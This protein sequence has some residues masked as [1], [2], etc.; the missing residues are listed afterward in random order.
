MTIARAKIGRLTVAAVAVFGLAVG[1]GVLANAPK[2][3]AAIGSPTVSASTTLGW[4]TRT[5]L[6]QTY[7]ANS[8]IVDSHGMDTKQSFSYSGG[9]FTPI[10]RTAGTYVDGSTHVTVGMPSGEM[11]AVDLTTDNISF[12]SAQSKWTGTFLKFASPTGS[13]VGSSEFTISALPGN[14]NGYWQPYSVFI[15]GGY[16]YMSLY[17]LTTGSETWTVA[18]TPTTVPNAKIGD[19][20]MV[21][22]SLSTPTSFQYI[23]GIANKAAYQTALTAAGYGPYDLP[24]YYSVGPRC[25]PTDGTKIVC[26][27]RSSADDDDSTRKLDATKVFNAAQSSQDSQRSRFYGGYVAPGVYQQA[28]E[29]GK[30]YA[31]KNTVKI[32][33]MMVSIT[34]NGG[35]SWTHKIIADNGG[36]D[37]NLAYD[38]A[39][40]L[41]VVAYGGQTYPRKDVAVQW[42]EDLGTTWSSPL[43]VTGGDDAYT[44]GTPTIFKTAAKTFVLVY[45]SLPRY[46]EMASRAGNPSPAVMPAEW[47]LMTRTITFP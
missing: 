36:I 32:P 21:R 44:T 2:A 15:D 37:G 10:T 31:P 25:I 12:D 27:T 33:P 3:E 42:S 41:L 24:L 18:G 23:G 26:I 35:T 7:A 45:D 1:G 46:F 29:K 16:I 14:S 5:P 47:R 38:S 17:R 13:S 9:A 22:A 34:S 20:W 40:N 19:T 8:F 28:L 11:W 4:A 39:N 6:G 43:T 30:Y